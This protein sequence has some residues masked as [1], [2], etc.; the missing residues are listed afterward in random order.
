MEVDKESV[1]SQHAAGFKKHMP[2]R[3]SVK[4]QVFVADELAGDRGRLRNKEL[5]DRQ[6]G[7]ALS[8][9]YGSSLR[10]SV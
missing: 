4:K 3:D 7:S 9:T 2:Q 6:N 8:F 10:S 1:Q 5:S